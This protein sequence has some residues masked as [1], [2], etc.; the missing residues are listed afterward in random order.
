MWPQ[1][2]A[3][4][5]VEPA[6]PP[7][8]GAP[9]APRM[10]AAADTWRAIAERHALV[11]PDVTRLASWWHTDGDLGRT[12]ECVNDMSKSRR[13]GFVQHRDTLQAFYGLFSRLVHERLIPG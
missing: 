2:A 6:G 11:E 3:Y 9:L 4:F 10:A 13:F 12:L 7:V 8:G 5:G 1:L